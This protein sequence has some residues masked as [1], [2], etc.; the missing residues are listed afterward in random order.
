MK[1]YSR[2]LKPYR[3]SETLYPRPKHY[4]LQPKLQNQRATLQTVNP[5]QLPLEVGPGSFVLRSNLGV[6]L[7]VHVS[8]MLIQIMGYC[9]VP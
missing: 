5:K 6:L 2:K 4:S 9:H 7:Q 1:P 8:A 3:L